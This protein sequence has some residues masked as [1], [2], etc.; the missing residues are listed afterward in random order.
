[1]NTGSLQIEEHVIMTKEM[2]GMRTKRN[3]C[4]FLPPQV[5][6][7]E[8]FAMRDISYTTHESNRIP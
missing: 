3:T 6:F 8:L 7:G 4:G 1:M 5:I 2:A